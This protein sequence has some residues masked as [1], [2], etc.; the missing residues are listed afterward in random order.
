[1]AP[2]FYIGNMTVVTE[3]EKNVVLD[4]VL[5]QHPAAPG[6]WHVIFNND[7]QTPMDFVVQVL[8][9]VFRHDEASAQHIMHK[10]H[11]DG[12]AVAGTYSFEIAEQKTNET[13]A[14]AR[15]NKFPLT[16]TIEQQ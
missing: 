14:L 1:M 13:T 11:E 7:N 9:M 5:S 6:K 3:I 8:Q 16:I 4:T 15:A 10:V 12:K 2:F